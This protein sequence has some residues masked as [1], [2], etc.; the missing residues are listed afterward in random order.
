MPDFSELR[1]NMVANQIAA[2]GVRS[3]KVLEAMRKVPREQ[4]LPVGVREFAYEDSPLPIEAG[5][6]ISQPYIVAFMI[7]GLALSGGEK[8]L[9]IGAGSGYAAAVL[10]EIAGEVYT[11]ERIE[12]L[13]LTATTA[14]EETG[15]TNVQV[16]HGDGTLG[17]PEHAPFDG[18]VVAAGGPEIPDSLK[19]Q[20]K[21]GGRM[22][23]PVGEIRE[24]QEL[25]RV[26]RVSEK[27]FETEDLA[28]VRFV[29]L[30]GAEGWDSE[31]ATISR[32][33]P[34]KAPDTDEEIRRQIADACEPFHSLE[35]A[36]LGPMLERIGDSHLVLIGEASHGTSE[37]YKMRS[38]ITSEL[39][40]K[41]NFKL[42]A[43]EGDWPDAARIDHYVRHFD[44]PPSEWTAFARF[45]MW[46]WR[47]N[48][49]R[50]F[51]DWLRIHNAGIDHDERVAF[52]GLDLY[53]LYSSIRS[54]L[55]YLDEVDPE[56]AKLAR[57]RYGCLT[58]WHADPATYGRAAITGSYRSCENEVVHMLIELSQKHRDYAEHDGERF[59]D[60]VQNARLVANA[61]RYYRVMYY[62]SRESWN[63]RDTYMFETLKSLRDFHKPNNKAVVWAHNSHVGNAAAT[64]MSKRGEI[65]IGQLCR[66]EFGDSVY[67]IGFGT[68]NGTVA[69]ASDWDGP[70]EVKQ[71][72]PS[73]RGSYDKLF[74]DVGLPGF[75]LGLRDMESESLKKAL[76]KS[77]IQRA[78][79]VIYRPET[80]LASH[81]FQ[82]ALPEQ[83]DEYVWIDTTE[84]VQPFETEEL[85]GLPD[86]Y[87]FGL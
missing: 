79:G 16:L 33:R 8:V 70:M 80:E 18:I 32:R 2:R 62:G 23:I 14:L 29:P 37:F 25:V 55:K 10:A 85:E 21:I 53:S 7:E 43:I 84:A 47:N 38:R 74:H 34:D 78:I 60:A 3:E 20:L 35:S 71:V 19:Q 68:D 75:F 30:V 51:I 77:R 81:Y 41:K 82:A 12:E 44:Y 66:E 15:Y 9:E 17:W 49:V 63:L 1:E 13:A 50:E 24:F 39:V 86:T 73:Q 83:F 22:V 59:L 54:V 67:S 72:Q 4:F 64:E 76:S 65:N 52:H 57:Q 40:R 26:T 11:I 58:P 56:A 5:Q 61:E 28:A 36:D 6:T 42:I 31:H 27:E 87:P 45:P 48:D 46:M 69:A